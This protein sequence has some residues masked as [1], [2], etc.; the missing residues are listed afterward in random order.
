MS[1][2]GKKPI[3]IPAGV[4]ISVN[5][6][7]IK[8]E[9]PK[10]TL[11]RNIYAGLKIDVDDKTV[12]I[13]R[14]SDNKKNRELHG[15]MR[16]LVSNM[17][18]GVDKGITKT[19]ELTGVGYRVAL[20]GKKLKFQLGYSHPVE[21]DEKEGVTFGVDG[22]TKVIISG[23]SRER[24][25]QVAAELK[26]LR[27]PDSYKGKGIRYLNEQIKLKPGKSGKGA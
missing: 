26:K 9:G 2:L 4:K 15:L 17:V 20:E 5:G 22:N 7:E 23:I 18:E 6:N 16:A 24:V 3:D 25:G 10:G 11:V 19:L 14:E 8:V 12:N 13:T 27:L 21:I 1:R